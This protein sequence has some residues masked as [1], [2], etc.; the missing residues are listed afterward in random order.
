MSATSTRPLHALEIGMAWEQGGGAGGLDRAYRD[1][2]L[3]LPEA[4]VRVTGI[5]LGPGQPSAFEGGV[6]HRPGAPDEPL[7]RRLFEIGRTVARVR[8]EDAPDIIASHFS[9]YALP[10]LLGLG[11]RPLVAHFHGPWAGES[12]AEGQSRLAVAAK[13]RLEAAVYRRAGRMIVLSK[14][15]GELA[16]REY[17]VAPE[18]VRV[19]PGQVAADRFDQ[20]GT[21][22]DA[23]AALGLPT[24]RPIVLSLRR[25]VRRM[26]L[27]RLIEALVE[28]RRSVPEILLC[29]G[30][31]GPER[32]ALERRVAELALER[33]VRF[34]GF[35][36][37]DDL[38]GLYRAADL[39]VLPSLLLEGFGL[40]AA[41]AL[42][43]GTPVL[44]TPTGGLP[45]VVAPL[46][47]E[48]VM[49]SS[50]PRDLA[51]AI[52]A[53]L[54]GRLPL[55]DAGACRAYA[56]ERFDPAAANRRIAEIYR[57]VLH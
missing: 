5:V 18:R 47:P 21:P 16:V 13:R 4:G 35:V 1:I 57:E 8:R 54:T 53:A 40:V 27:D 44:V 10:A 24:D 52:G 56:R 48:L 49:A 15:F 45:E 9:L 7:A 3:G 50:E 46:A 2:C 39:V 30:G 14:A 12:A 37:E 22:A 20:V 33:H 34:L 28:V 36:P 51:S 11:D 29:I 55:P 31:R 41:E 26:G 42:A 38:P 43:A 25:L 32:A 6:V 19:V 17:G 23:R